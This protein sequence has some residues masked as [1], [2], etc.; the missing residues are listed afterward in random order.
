MKKEKIVQPVEKKKSKLQEY[1]NL[2]LRA[3][4]DYQNLQ[5]EVFK[6]R[7]EWAKMSKVQAIEE[8]LPVFDNFTTAFVHQEKLSEDINWQNWAKGIEYIK[9]QFEDILIQS[10]VEIIKTVGEDFDP[11]YHEAVSEEESEEIESGKIIKEVVVGYKVG[12]KILKV[13]KVVVAK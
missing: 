12:D 13:A 8:F 3:Q 4:A 1:K 6:Q 7:A 11:N 9:K 5:K 2:A 10:G